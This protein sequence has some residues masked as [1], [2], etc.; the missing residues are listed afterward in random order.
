M[1]KN[2]MEPVSQTN[3]CETCGKVE[4]PIQE[5]SV[6][7]WLFF[8]NRCRCALRSKIISGTPALS[9]ARRD[10]LPI[11]DD[12][13]ELI[14]QI[15]QGGMGR[16]FKVR[17][18]GTDTVLALKVMDSALTKDD[19]A[20][21]RFQKE[22]DAC[23]ALSHPN[24]VKVYGT[25]TTKS[26]EPFLIMDYLDG[27][28][29]QTIM[30]EN[31]S[32]E[33]KR[34]LT[35]MI[36]VAEALAVAHDAGVVHRD[37][38]PSNIMVTTSGGE[39]QVKVLDFGIAKILP[40][41]LDHTQSLT[42]TGDIFGSPLYMSPEQ[43]KG[44]EVDERADIYSFGCV[45]YEMLNGAPP[46]KGANTLETILEHVNDFPKPIASKKQGISNEL[47]IVVLKCLEKDPSERYQ[48][49][50]QLKK[51]LKLLQAGLQ[52]TAKPSAAFVKR[53]SK[54]RRKKLV[55]TATICLGSVVIVI[56]MILI[57]ILV[58]HQG[59]SIEAETLRIEQDPSN[60]SALAHRGYMLLEKE[61]Y[62][63]AI[64]DLTKAIALKPDVR[65]CHRWRA[66]CYQEVGQLD[67][68]LMDANQAVLLLPNDGRP[69]NQ[70]A[71]ILMEMNR[72]KEA[73]ADFDRTLA[74]FSKPSVFSEA[75]VAQNNMALCYERK[76]LILL[77]MKDYRQT[78]ECASKAIEINSNY[79]ECYYL[80]GL[81]L[82][83]RGK[84][85]TARR[86]VESALEIS[87]SNPSYMGTRAKLL[88]IAG[89]LEEARAE[90]NSAISLL[91]EKSPGEKQ[92]L[93]IREWIET[94]TT[95]QAGAKAL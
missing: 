78:I 84:L 54:E 34:A 60:Y 28:T 62:P 91:P 25:S 8:D 31:G 85:Y 41:G 64:R 58:L 73:L 40:T 13:Y 35:L 65:H 11:L 95:K 39:E 2:I 92:L 72:P 81:A 56:G 36:N 86:D 55:R 89:R 16:V 23:L 6:T 33:P 80:R 30:E 93:L 77:R 5:G 27:A 7:S 20:M 24:L 87:P 49:A 70:R 32:I 3:H 79:H 1:T 38:K 74:I 67:K 17:E 9:C 61:R 53:H 69:Y 48:S 71:A 47:E 10:L 22:A 46:F 94:L 52:P 44:V 59:N 50:D 29:L 14:E 83:H 26:G 21:A 37:I 42:A 88:A 66:H 90:I 51:D 12:Q 15:G 4:R 19:E 82:L 18:Q 43:C 45:L 76:A 75:T 68:A 57:P 63:D